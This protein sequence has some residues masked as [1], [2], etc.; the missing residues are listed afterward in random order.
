MVLVRWPLSATIVL[1]RG[2][3]SDND[4]LSLSKED[5]WSGVGYQFISGVLVSSMALVLLAAVSYQCAATW[6]WLRTLGLS[7]EEAQEGTPDGVKQNSI[8]ISH[9]L[10]DLQ[11]EPTHEYVQEKDSKK[12]RPLLSLIDM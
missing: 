11:Q 1:P 7:E 6:K 9:S 12:V 8:R 10:P 2:S 5:E 4:G 3:S